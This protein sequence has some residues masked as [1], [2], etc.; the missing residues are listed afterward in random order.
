MSHPTLI[1]AQALAELERRLGAGDRLRVAAVPV[2][3][4]PL[5]FVRAAAPLS[6]W[7]G[8]AG[9]PGQVELGGAGLAWRASGGSGSGRLMRLWAAVRDLRL[10]ADARLFTAFSFS[11]QGPQR[12]E[13]DGFSAATAVLAAATVVATGDGTMLV[14]AVPPGRRPGPVLDMLKRLEDPG[15]VLPFDVS[16]HSLESRPA[17]ALWRQEVEEAVAAIRAGSF[18]KA[19]LARSVVVRTGAP[20]AP[21]DLLA[22]L[23]ERYPGCHA[24]GWREAD[25]TYIGASP[26]LLVARWGETVVSHPHAGSAPRGEGEDDDVALGELLMASAKDR[27]EHA[28][29]VEDVAARLRP[30]TSHLAV[31]PEPSLRKMATVQHLSSRIEGRLRRP[32]SVL[33]LA[34][35]LHPTPAVGGTPRDEALAFIDKV[36]GIDRGWYVGGVGWTDPGGDGEV[37]VSLRSGLLRGDTARLYAGAGIVAGSDP[38]AELAETRLK[39][40]PLLDL[41]AAT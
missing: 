34:E 25:A 8:F 37:A 7:V 38:E 3:A 17:P 26:E 19:V 15:P 4:D 41:L 16:G 9:R 39:F 29:V 36:E 30:L 27:S 31:P 1:P 12:P 10:G 33:E 21:F 23:R 2:E 11:P 18:R 5:T 20:P 6:G 35:E 40:R 32:L 24:F 13:W 14:A 28:L 22:Q